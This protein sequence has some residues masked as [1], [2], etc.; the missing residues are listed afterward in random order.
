MKTWVQN[1]CSAR[2]ILGIVV[3]RR[4]WQGRFEVGAAVFFQ[5]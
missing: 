2:G 5:A 4:W 3:P 1:A